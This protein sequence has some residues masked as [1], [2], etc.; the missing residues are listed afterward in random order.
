[1]GVEPTRDICCPPTDLKSAKPTGTYPLPFRTTSI[2]VALDLATIKG[3][4]LFTEE[5]LALY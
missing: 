1:M 4:G 2:I 3:G 5:S